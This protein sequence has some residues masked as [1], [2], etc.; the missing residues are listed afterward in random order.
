MKT[1]LASTRQHGLDWVRV[2]AFALL[3]FYHTGMFFVTWDFHFKNPDTS[4]SMELWMLFLSQWRLSLLF[5][6]SG[7][8]VAFALRKRTGRQF[9]AERFKRLFLP[10]LF[11]MFVVVPPQIY[12]E[13]LFKHQFSGSY[14][15]FYSL[16]LQ[17]K[18]YPE[19]NFS[20]HHLWF[21]LYL[22]VYSLVGLPLFRWL[23]KES[24]QRFMAK[25]TAFFETKPAT[26]Y[27][28]AAPFWAYFMF[29]LPKF[30]VTHGLFDDWFN[31]ALSFTVFVYGYVLASQSRL[32]EVVQKLRKV[33]LTGGLVCFAVML[34][35]FSL[36]LRGYI[37]WIPIYEAEPHNAA[38]LV[39][40]TLKSLNMWFWM[41]A[42]LGFALRHLN[43]S[44]PFL[45][46]ATEAVYPFYILHQ[47]VML[48]IGYYIVQWN[49][50][51][52]PKFFAVAL[53]MF[54]VTAVLYEV[55][56]RR[57]AVTRFLFGLK[58]K[59]KVAAAQVEMKA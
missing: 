1:P 42:I 12:M 13:R 3:I 10:L 14:F 18:P 35:G 27:A 44:N 5:L 46:Y 30:D 28:L 17:F 23:Q 33:S 36:P 26:L 41:L 50:G 24:G 58:P 34:V 29:L 38:Y 20:W 51:V 25:A 56:V 48:V 32:L 4:R 11:G 40:F 39:Y 59:P 45:T 15:D 57:F 31:H 53:G 43:F 9:A 2:I 37:T 6:V 22:F 7:A 54:T 49:T 21:V 16:V 8:G 47:T 55:V 52:V 19:G